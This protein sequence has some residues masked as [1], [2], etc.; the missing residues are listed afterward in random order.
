MSE[1]AILIPCYNEAPAIGGVVKSFKE[2]DPHAS[3][4]VYDNNSTDETAQ[5]AKDAGAIVV[6]E[7]RQG[8]GY[9]MRSMF[10]EIEA[11][12]YIM[13][14]GDGTYD[15][16]DTYA[17]GEDILTGRAD[18]VIG[19]RLSSTYF[20]ENTRFGHNA[21]NKLICWLINTIF[22]SDVRDVMTGARA[23][24]R[25][26]VKSCASLEAGFEIEIEITT[27]ALDKNFTMTQHPVKYTD[28]IE[29]SVSKLDTI[30]DGLRVLKTIFALFK[31]FRPL[32]FFSL[33]SAILLLAALGFFWLP[34]TDYLQTGVTTRLPSMTVAMA[35]G[36]CALLSMVCGVIL[37][38]IRKQSRTLVEIELMHIRGQRPTSRMRQLQEQQQ[39]ISDV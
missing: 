28:R 30:P 14:D 24:S 11:D 19:D 21:G 22:K 5:I 33:F 27:H 31:D 16:G 35:L 26:F 36:V 23:F 10:S 34:L 6:K 7:Y 37:D 25:P 15:A 1:I 32:F 12:V 9:V 29:G 39:Q 2:I 20:T 18:I 13:I 3:V 8:K 4:Y 17:L 38:S